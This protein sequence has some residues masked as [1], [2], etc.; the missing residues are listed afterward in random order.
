M[1]TPSESP[2]HDPILPVD[3]DDTPASSSRDVT[4]TTPVQA[5][6]VPSAQ[7]AALVSVSRNTFNYAIIGFTC[8]IVGL[9]VGLIVYD[10]INQNGQAETM[11]M[12]DRAVS[13]AVAAVPQAL[14]P[15]PIPTRDP[16]LRYEVPVAG[17]PS[18]GPEDAPITM[19]EFGDFNCIWCK[20][21]NDS[22]LTPLLQAY[23][24]RIRF[25]YRDYPILA[26]SSYQAALAAECA[27]DQ[28]RFWEFHNRFYATPSNLT[29]DAFLQYA[30]ETQIDVAQ[31]TT[32]LDTAAHQDDVLTGDRDFAQ[33]L[34]IRGTPTFF[35][36]GKM[37]TGGQPYEVFAAAIEAE[38]ALLSG[39]GSAE[40]TAQAGA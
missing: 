35:I 22:T 33:S 37:I 16:N 34:G 38:L 11:A 21:F 25:V 10:R 15:T 36:N 2:E 28:G 19:I 13:T 1:L 32:C 14:V 17:N 12:V 4:Y 3:S 18:I 6:A 8:F 24:G 23:E 30:T 39:A 20:R 7:D 40:S 31:F 9:F 27:D 5:K 29:R 26:D